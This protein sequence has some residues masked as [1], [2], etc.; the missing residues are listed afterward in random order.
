MFLRIVVK[1]H[2]KMIIKYIGMLIKLKEYI[3][4]KS[5]FD[6]TVIKLD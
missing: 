4:V 2:L 1:I 6:L 5:N 3:D